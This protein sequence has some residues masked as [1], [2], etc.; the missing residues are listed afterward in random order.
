[1][2]HIRILLQGTSIM[3][4]IT[5]I[6][7]N[8]GDSSSPG[9]FRVGKK[10]ALKYNDNL[11]TYQRSVEKKINAL[12]LAVQRQDPR[13][14][15]DK[16][17]QLQKLIETSADTISQIQGFAGDT[18]LR[19]AFLDQ[20][21]FY[22]SLYSE[23]GQD[24]IDGFISDPPAENLNELVKNFKKRLN[25]EGAKVEK[26]LIATQDIFFKKFKLTR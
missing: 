21:E 12:N 14:I 3:V 16:L 20:L 1:M 8:C 26:K 15:Q 18:S 5:L 19:D 11:V 24:M 23:E 13:E 6:F 2:K 7:F 4:F 22:E 9:I 25:T 10:Q 17:T